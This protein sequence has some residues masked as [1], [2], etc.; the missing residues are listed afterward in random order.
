MQANKESQTK[1]SSGK[2]VNPFSVSEFLS[3]WFDTLRFSFEF[4]DIYFG[5]TMQTKPT[6]E[7]KMQMWFKF[8][9]LLLNVNEASM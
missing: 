2:T 6:I 9:L 3:W 4:K 7:E 1:H 8:S 5:F